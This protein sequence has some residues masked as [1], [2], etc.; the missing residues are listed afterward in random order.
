MSDLLIDLVTDA[1]DFERIFDC[2]REA[3]GRQAKDGIWSAVHP[4]WDTSPERGAARMLND[5]RASNSNSLYLKATLPDPAH[6]GQRVIVGY[7]KWVQL[8][9]VEGKGEPSKPLDPNSD[10]L[11]LT[12][13]A[14]RRFICQ[15]LNSLHRP[16]F[17]L[18]E[19]KAKTDS[20]AIM[21]L[22]LCGVHPGFQRKG[23][24][25]KLVQRGLAEANR[26]GGLEAC[27][28]ASSMGRHVYEKLGFRG[29]EADIKFEVDEEFGQ[30]TKPS[31]L[32]MRTGGSV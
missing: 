4:D 15:M 9:S 2:M 6:A 28:E 19:A 20:P 17:E 14:E 16:R 18:V 27:T 3:F 24:A 1:S 21:V 23:I 11:Y 13:E 32:F 5:W 31:N 25:S 22:D 8:S 12:N 26:R 10:L 30:P 7:A 29:G